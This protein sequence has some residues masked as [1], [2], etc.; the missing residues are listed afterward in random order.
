MSITI[1]FGSYNAPSGL[2]KVLAKKD[3]NETGQELP[4]TVILTR[5]IDYTYSASLLWL[6]IR[7]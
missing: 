5:D 7:S 2:P 3:G 4:G 6:S 1:Y